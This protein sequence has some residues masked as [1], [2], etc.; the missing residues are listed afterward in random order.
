MKPPGRVSIVNGSIKGI[1]ARGFRGLRAFD[2]TVITIVFSPT[3]TGVETSI[4][5]G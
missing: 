2:V 1:K 4:V 5:S 3:A